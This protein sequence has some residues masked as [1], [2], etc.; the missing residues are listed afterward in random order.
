M[1]HSWR[2]IAAREYAALVAACLAGTVWTVILVGLEAKGNR[3][4][5]ADATWELREAATARREAERALREAERGAVADRAKLLEE[6]REEAAD[7]RG[8]DVAAHRDRPRDLRRLL[9][10]GGHRE[11]GA[12][13]VR[14]DEPTLRESYLLDVAS[15]VRER[16][17]IAT[18]AEQ[19]RKAVEL[20]LSEARE[21][22]QAVAAALASSPAE[23]LRSNLAVES[24]STWSGCASVRYDG[25]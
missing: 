18:R 21:R 15:G 6:I 5:V 25:R 12:R 1:N 7:L 17:D 19:R 13:E 11:E 14:P 8:R 20:R 4:A 16:R 2:Y 23:Y 24:D 10:E 9:S 22:P 3:Q